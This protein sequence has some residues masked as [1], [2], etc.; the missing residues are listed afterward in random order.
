[1]ITLDTQIPD[2]PKKLL[3][4]PDETTYHKLQ[5]EVDEKIDAINTK[6]K[7]LGERFTER[8]QQFKA[9][10][11]PKKEGNEEEAGLA[12]TPSASKELKTLFEQVK[13]KDT[14]RKIIY[15]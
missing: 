14:E 5:A 15:N 10:S 9:A 7:E 4:Q 6:V 3:E 1:M 12:L 2:L 13:E 11:R 8:L